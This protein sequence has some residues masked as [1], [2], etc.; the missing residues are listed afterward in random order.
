MVFRTAA[1]L[2]KTSSSLETVLDW[3]MSQKYISLKISEFPL[4]N[5]WLEDVFPT[6]VVPF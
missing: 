3:S 1:V 4:E 6:E 2:T 5:Q